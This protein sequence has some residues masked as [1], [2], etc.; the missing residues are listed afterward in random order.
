MG[1]VRALACIL[2]VAGVACAAPV[3]V[4]PKN[5]DDDASPTALKLL[6]NRKI[7]K[8]LKLNAEQRIAIVDGL[9]DIDETIDK[10]RTALLKEPNATPDR[11]EKLEKDHLDA[12]VKLLKATAAKTLTPSQRSRLKQITRQ[13]HGPESFKDLALQRLLAFTDAQKKAVATFEKQL[14][15]KITSYLSLLGNDDSD[16]RKEE[17]LKFREESLKSL[18]AGLA[19]DQREVWKSLLGEPVKGFDAV[20]LWFALLEEDDDK[21]VP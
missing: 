8:E 5:A 14:E 6:K 2:I 17:L 1:S 20:E 9:A 4:L 21:P 10:K 12:N 18:V 15:E 3:P 13:I 19:M 7:Q 11:F 16:N